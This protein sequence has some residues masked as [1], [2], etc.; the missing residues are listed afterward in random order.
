M[1]IARACPL[2][3]LI[4]LAGCGGGS[5]RRH[6]SAPSPRLPAAARVTTQAGAPVATIT[7][8]GTIG[9]AI[10]DGRGGWFVAGAF[11]RLD[12]VPARGLAHVLHGGR[13]DGAWRGA[14]A[15]GSRPTLLALAANGPPGTS[16]GVLYAAAWIDDEDRSEFAALD[17]VTGRPRPVPAVSELYGIDALAVVGDELLVAQATGASPRAP[18]CL[19]AYDTHTG[20]PVPGFRVE[21]HMQPELG[22]IMRLTPAGANV[23]VTG[24]FRRIDGVPSNG[25]A[26][27]DAT[28]GA[29]RHAR[30]PV[31]PASAPAGVRSG[32]EVLTSP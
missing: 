14:L 25:S 10:A 20:R 12:G 27:I 24:Y 17:A 16:T 11:T 23:A 32:G 19:H 30:G 1:R 5:H 2:A 18:S 9:S 22:C 28:T 26:L 6:G 15:A 31:R 13:V 8:D 29:L 7:G 21:V 3:V 4:L